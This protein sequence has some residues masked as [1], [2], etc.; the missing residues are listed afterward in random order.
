VATTSTKRGGVSNTSQKKVPEDGLGLRLR[1]SKSV[2][3]REDGLITLAKGNG[4][5]KI[6][7][8][9]RTLAEK[10]GIEKVRA[11]DK[12]REE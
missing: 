12:K 8:A 2:Y 9:K 3:G 5:A 10:R 1:G 4:S 6:G 11:G 7:I